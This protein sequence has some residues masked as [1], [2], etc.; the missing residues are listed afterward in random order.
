MHLFVERRFLHLPSIEFV[1]IEHQR[2]NAKDS[3]YSKFQIKIQQ[4]PFVIVHTLE[5]VDQNIHLPTKSID[6]HH[7]K[8]PSNEKIAHQV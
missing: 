4:L 8:V 3:I 5:I 1:M 7:R 2:E 6:Y